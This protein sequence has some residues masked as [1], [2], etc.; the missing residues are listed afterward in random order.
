MHKDARK[1]IIKQVFDKSDL[2]SDAE[3]VT[4]TYIF[5]V[6]ANM[7]EE[8]RKEAEELLVMND[9]RYEDLVDVLCN[10]NLALTLWNGDFYAA[11][12]GWPFMTERHQ[13]MRMWIN[14]DNGRLLRME[15]S[16]SVL[17][18]LFTPHSFH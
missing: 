10:Q 9:K 8:Y 13:R 15:V 4:D 11:N 3:R 14:R 7:F 12:E 5:N 16:R 17:D 2:K 18:R 6:P 1:L